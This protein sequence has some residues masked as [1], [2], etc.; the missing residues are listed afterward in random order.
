[1]IKPLKGYLIGRKRQKMKNE[2]LA[3]RL[4]RVATAK[5][6]EPCRLGYP[7]KITKG[8]P[9][10]PESGC[11]G[12]NAT[13]PCQRSG[14]P[15]WSHRYFDGFPISIWSCAEDR[16]IEGDIELVCP[17]VRDV[18]FGGQLRRDENSIKRYGEGEI[19]EIFSEEKER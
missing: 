5:D 11:P 14:H 13:K 8:H 16:Q 17:R 10:Y 6:L 2:K 1:V 18:F 9:Q 7:A 12:F 4:E 3:F 15:E 19:A